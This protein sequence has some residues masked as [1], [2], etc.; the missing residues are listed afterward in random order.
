MSGYLSFAVP[1]TIPVGASSTY[2]TIR[3]AYNSLVFPIGGPVVIELQSDYAP[4][5]DEGGVQMLVKSANPANTITIT[6][7]AGAGPFTYNPVVP[8]ANEVFYLRGAKYVIIDGRNLMTINNDHGSGKAITFDQGASN[9]I[10][11]NCVISGFCPSNGG[12]V[13]VFGAQQASA[14]GCD[15]NVIEYCRIKAGSAATPI[16]LIFSTSVNTTQSHDNNTIRYCELSDNHNNLY[17]SSG[18]FLGAYNNAWTITNNHFYQTTSR[19]VAFNLC[20]YGVNISSPTGSGFTINNNFFG[21]TAANC[22]GTALTITGAGF[23]RAI[24]MVT[25]ITIFNEINSNTFKNIDYSST[26]NSNVNSLITFADGRYHFGMSGGNTIGSMTATDDIHVRLTGTNTW[27][28]VINVGVG[29]TPT[30]FLGYYNNIGG[31]TFLDPNL[32]VQPPRFGIFFADFKSYN[33]V[34]YNNIGGSVANSIHNTSNG[35]LYAIFSTSGMTSWQQGFSGNT[36]QNMSSDNTGNK[37]QVLGIY[38]GDGGYYRINSNIITDLTT[39]SS[40]P[41]TD[42]F[43]SVIGICVNAKAQTPN[44]IDLNV[45]KNLSNT[46]TTGAVYVSGINFSA[47]NLLGN[48]I[49]RNNIYNLSIESS[50]TSA[51]MSG[52]DVDTANVELTTNMISLSSNGNHI[53]YGIESHAIYNLKAYYNSVYIGGSPS[54]ANNNTAAMSLRNTSATMIIKDNILYNARTST[55][56]NYALVIG[57][58]TG[59]LSNYNDLYSSNSNNIASYNGGTTPRTLEVWSTN[60]GQDANSVSTAIVFV[61]TASDLHLVTASALDGV[62]IPGITADCDGQTRPAVPCM[63]FDDHWTTWTG[64]ANSRWDVLANWTNG[65]PKTYSYAT[66]P[67]VTNK[68]SVSWGDGVARTVEIS[69]NG[70]LTIAPTKTL[71]VNGTVINNGSSSDLIVK[72]D[73]TG[74]GNLIASNLVS[75]IAQRYIKTTSNA[76]FH[77]FGSPITSAPSSVLSGPYTYTSFASYPIPGSGYPWNIMAAN[78]APGVGYSKSFTTATTIAF[79]GTLNTGKITPTLSSTASDWNFLGNPYPCTL[80]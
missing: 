55:G 4:S 24:Y 44:V 13:V 32:G 65:T 62:T 57:T 12:G 58:A 6:V 26:N 16:N 31:I 47:S 11:R 48:K 64:A 3:A 22:G 30:W 68:P 51:G 29:G 2:Q 56:K 66:I 53:L 21:G 42:N 27:Y 77:Y 39:N 74:T 1:V 50:S 79:D 36:I 67:S 7:A 80:R 78:L 5:G 75:G 76:N 46:N 17:S 52:I 15:N 41:G 25:G 45:V 33:Y 23:Y 72:S 35:L 54:I 14:T 71:T 37:G 61:N 43:A 10:V 19:V 38:G 8:A 28:S 49:D 34:Q 20:S 9:N 40:N 69:V 73:A 60:T 59:V 70:G 63:G 18:I